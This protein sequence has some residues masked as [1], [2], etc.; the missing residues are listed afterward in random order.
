M[1]NVPV[2]GLGNIRSCVTTPHVGVWGFRDPVYRIRCRY[3][4]QV[5]SWGY[6]ANSYCLYGHQGKMYRDKNCSPTQTYRDYKLR[7]GVCNPNV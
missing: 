4:G 5:R 3:R 2:V 1:V 7:P 6:W